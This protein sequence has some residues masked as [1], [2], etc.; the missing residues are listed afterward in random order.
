M[1]SYLNVTTALS[2]MHWHL[3]VLSQ[4]GHKLQILLLCSCSNYV[5]N[6]LSCSFSLKREV[7]GS[8]LYPVRLDTML[9]PTARQHRCDVYSKAAVPLLHVGAMTQKF[10]PQTYST[11]RQNI[12][13]IPKIWLDVKNKFLLIIKITASVIVIT[14]F[15]TFRPLLV[16]AHPNYI[17]VMTKMKNKHRPMSFKH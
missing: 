2:Q 14:L 17:L 10:A 12:A 1:L 8:N 5:A 13:S 9:L 6:W 16:K 7:W 3:F 15:W 11:F 4:G